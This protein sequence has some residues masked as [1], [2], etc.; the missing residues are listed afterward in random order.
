MI[1][2]I[3]SLKRE[4]PG[5]QRLVIPATRGA[6]FIQTIREAQ[7]EFTDAVEIIS[8]ETFMGLSVR[9]GGGDRLLVE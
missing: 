6:E 8:V 7:L 9:L 5:A 4:N 2:E 1:K 3:A